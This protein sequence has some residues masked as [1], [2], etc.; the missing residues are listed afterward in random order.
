MFLCIFPPSRHDR[1]K[2][3]TYFASLSQTAQDTYAIVSLVNGWQAHLH[4]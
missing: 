3:P 4:C 1:R 2:I